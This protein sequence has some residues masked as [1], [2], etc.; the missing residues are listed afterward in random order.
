MADSFTVDFYANDAGGTIPGT[1]LAT[2][3][4]TEISKTPEPAIMPFDGFDYEMSLD[5]P[6]AQ[7]AGTLWVALY[8]DR[9]FPGG[10]W[11]WSKTDGGD[12]LAHFN[13]LA[14]VWTPRAFPPF[15]DQSFQLLGTLVPVPATL[16]L[17]GLPVAGIALGAR[18]RESSGAS[19]QTRTRPLTTADFYI[20]ATT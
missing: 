5:S 11:K 4:L 1:F 18:R 20:P 2:S 17:L 12:G 3:A 15:E 6:V 7:P 19:L 10:R 13:P 14:A 16:I 8:S 9:G